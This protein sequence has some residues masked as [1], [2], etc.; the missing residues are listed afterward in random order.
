MTRPPR[1]LV[2]DPGASWSTADVWAGL[3]YGLLQHGVEVIPYSLAARIDNAG[4]Y[5]NHAWRRATKLKKQTAAKLGQAFEPIPKPTTAEIQYTA[6]IYALDA[7]LRHQVDAVII[8]SAMFFHPNVIHLMKRAKL[9]VFVL[10]TESPYDIEKE[11]DRARIVDG[12]WTNERSSVT[13]FRAVNP[14]SGYCAHAWNPER[15]RP[16]AQAADKV[17]AHDVV[18][19]G[20]AFRERVQWF[21]A[22][23]W[24]GIDLA[25]Y[26]T[27]DMLG[28]RSKLRQYVKAGQID[29]RRAA[30]LYRRAKIG[31]NLYRTSIGWG[32]RA[33]SI[34]HAESLNPR[35]Y[36]LAAC[37]A[38]HLSDFRAEVPEVFGELVPTFR[39]PTEAAALIR[40]WLAD[41]AGRAQIAG[42]LPA[43]VAESSWV[44]RA[45]TVIGDIET[46]LQ[47]DIAPAAVAVGG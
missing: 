35:A 36:E 8:V 31:L 39:T 9:K 41:D 14:C 6:S 17:P 15:H 1:F 32:R 47:W 28:A 7:A 38:F 26:G 19:V 42:A 27:W 16:G 4:A 11:L 22:I 5:L 25:L 44:H 43:C 30:A 33:P 34:T 24:T 18:F 13:T 2:V 10:F 21:E 46:L 3:C 12:C 29:N 23:D 45:R 20:S 40:M 37:G